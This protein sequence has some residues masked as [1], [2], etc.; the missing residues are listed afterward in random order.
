[1]AAAAFQRIRSLEFSRLDRTAHVYFDYTGAGLYSESQ[2]RFYSELLLDHV[3][4]NPHSLNPSSLESTKIVEQTRERIRAFF[5]AEDYEVIFTLNATAALKL[6]A[7]S[8]DFEKKGDFLLTADNHNSGNGIRE[9]AKIKHAATRYIPLN[10]ELR[11]DSIEDYLKGGLGLFAYPAQSNFS[12]V[13]HPL[14]W[15]NTAQALGYDVLL[16]AAAYVPSNPMNLKEI[17]ADFVPISFY[18]M[19]G[20]PTGVGALLVRAGKLKELHRPWFSGGTIRYVSTANDTHLFM[21][22]PQAFEDGTINFLSILAISQGLDF[23]ERIGM[24]N[25]SKHVLELTKSLLDELQLLNHSN[26]KP[27]VRIYGPKTTENRG[28]TVAFNLLDEDGKEIDTQFV[29]ERAVASNISV[30][31]GCFCN[32]GAAEFAFGHP[33]SKSK[34]CFDSLSHEKFTL[35]DFSECLGGKPV[36]AIRASLGIASNENDLERLISML[37]RFKNASPRRALLHQEIMPSRF[38]S[39]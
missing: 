32:P 25:I 5:G 21:D 38:D 30:R 27:L 16:D 24:D 7:E 8:Y 29:A 1:M 23:L 10:L 33:P 15:V 19:L 12:G 36:G 9:F 14:S 28:G 26:G 34:E 39:G 18:K 37:E 6:I 2:I 3:L 4:G 22:G 13:K 35:E 11:V 31:T 20:F 17:K